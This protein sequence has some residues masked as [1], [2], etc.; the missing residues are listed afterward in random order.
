M[1][2]LKDLYLKHFKKI[3]CYL[4]FLSRLFEM[5]TK[6]FRKFKHE[7]L[8][9]MIQ[10]KHLFKRFNKIAS[11]QKVINLQEERSNILQKL[12]DESDNHEREKIY[13]KMINKY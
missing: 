3:T 7:V 6:E 12:H 4:I 2:I 11:V 1:S 5:S 13:Q 9:F 10:D 8:K